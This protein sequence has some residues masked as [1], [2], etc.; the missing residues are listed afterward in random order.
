MCNTFALIDDGDIWILDGLERHL[1]QVVVC[2]FLSL[3]NVRSISMRDAKRSLRA[4]K[5][6]DLDFVAAASSAL[7]REIIEPFALKAQNRKNSETCF[8]TLSIFVWHPWEVY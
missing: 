7:Y 5:E 4:L 2:M 1:V 3:R 8:K 6:N